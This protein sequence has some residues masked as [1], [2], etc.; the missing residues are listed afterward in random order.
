MKI[1]SS[2]IDERVGAKKGVHAPHAVLQVEREM[3]EEIHFML[4][5][6]TARTRGTEYYSPPR[7][8][9]SIRLPVEEI[10]IRLP[11]EREPEAAQTDTGDD[12]D[13]AEETRPC[14]DCGILYRPNCSEQGCDGW[15][16]K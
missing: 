12:D 10:S 14:P 3:L 16:L 7:E 2:S 15:P 9:I 5:E 1:G 8:E 11:V 4:R 13:A 6:L